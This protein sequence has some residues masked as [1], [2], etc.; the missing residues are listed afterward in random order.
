MKLA[1]ALESM[2]TRREKEWPELEMV[3]GMINCDDGEFLLE[4][5]LISTPIPTNEQP[6]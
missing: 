5:Q 1:S 2:K 4:T 3:A 6:F